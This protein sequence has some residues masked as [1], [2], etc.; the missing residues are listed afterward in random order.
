MI[1]YI[2]NF[3]GVFKIWENTTIENWPVNCDYFPTPFSHVST[4][5]AIKKEYLPLKR[6]LPD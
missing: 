4:L 1:K 5:F 6:K 2:T 3:Y